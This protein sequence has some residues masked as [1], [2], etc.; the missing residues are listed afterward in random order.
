MLDEGL[1]IFGLRHVELAKEV[2]PEAPAWPI[3]L[4]NNSQGD[5][6]VV[7]FFED[8]PKIAVRPVDRML[9]FWSHVVTRKEGA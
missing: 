4:K 7:K 1:K 2:T 6:A 9:A 3:P 8:Q 5:L